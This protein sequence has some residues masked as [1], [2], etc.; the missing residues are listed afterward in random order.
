MATHTSVLENSLRRFSWAGV[1]L[2]V[3]LSGLGFTVAWRS[4]RQLSSDD[5]WVSH[6]HNVR[7][8][9]E[10]VLA[11]VTEIQT[12]ARAYAASG[13]EAFLVTYRNGIDT[14]Q[15]D[16]DTL[17]TL[18]ADN[19]GQQERLAKLRLQIADR[20]Q[21]AG[22]TVAARRKSGQVPATAI[23]RE[24]QRKMDVV[25][26]TISEMQREETRNL[27]L[28]QKK[29]V[30]TRKQTETFMLVSIFTG[31]TLLIVAGTITGREVKHNGLLIEEIQELNADLEERVEQQTAELRESQGRLAGVFESAMDAILSIDERQ[32]V[33]LFNHAAETMFRCPAADAM[34]QPLDRF[35]PQRFRGGHSEHIR[36]FADAGETSRSMGGLGALWALRSTGEEIPIEA[37]ISQ[38]EAGGKKTFTVII[39]DISEHKQAVEALRESQQRLRLFIEHAPAA[40][41]MFD[42]GM[43]YIQVSQRWLT[44]YGLDAETVSGT[45]HY[46][47]FPELPEAWKDAHRRT[48]AGEVLRGE[49]DRFDRSDGSKHWI[50]WETHP[51]YESNG[52]VGGI[53]IF[54]E[55]ITDRKRAAEEVRRLNE[56]LEQRVAERTAQLSA[57]NNELEA[58]TYSVSHDLRAPLRHISGFSRIVLDEYGAGLPAEAQR[59]LQRVDEGSRRMGQ[60]VDELLNLAKVGRRELTFQVVG[61]R[62]LVDEVIAD[63]KPETV[64]RDME[65]KVGD[66]TFADCDARLVRQ[67]FQNLLLNAVKFTRPRE[68]AIIEIGQTEQEGSPVIYV[69]DNGV[70]F[71]MKY[72]D[73]L[74]GVFQRLHRAEDFEGTGVG[75]ATVHRIVQKHGG[76]IWAEAELDQGAT[77]YFTLAPAGKKEVNAAAAAAGDKS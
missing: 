64:D 29:A 13:D 6:T 35:I 54:T 48:I 39:R 69:R 68:R 8:A 17:A 49:S 50:R 1:T 37:S 65:W 67:I 25:R 77:F 12:G 71:S 21:T 11:H 33:V 15:G 31:I 51:W 3:L 5:E 57:A 4:V 52:E 59:Y 20:L 56:E 24:G 58:F 41:A 14:F 10:D 9:I 70:G 36:R 32:C 28:R 66:L 18:V 16:L 72:A 46:D 45:S 55:D 60:L 62:A 63:L 2:G 40:L 38:Y 44:D 73:K 26:A 53:V 30:R 47:V 19:P 23:F 22:D 74:F 43:N 27:E 75:L 61:L 42:R 34:G 76:K 7:S